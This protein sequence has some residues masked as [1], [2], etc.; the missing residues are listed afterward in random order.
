MALVV[1]AVQDDA[2]V[3]RDPSHFG[4]IALLAGVKLRAGS[5]V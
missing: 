3:R 2:E 1:Q 5:D 4:T